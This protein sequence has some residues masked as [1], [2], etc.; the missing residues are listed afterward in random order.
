MIKWNTKVLM[1]RK[2]TKEE[3][4]NDMKIRYMKT[5]KVSEREEKSVFPQA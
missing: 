2:A 1:N 3:F 4:V 5:G